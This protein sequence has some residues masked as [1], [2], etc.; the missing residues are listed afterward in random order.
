MELTR[1]RLVQGLTPIAGM[2]GGCLGLEAPGTDNGTPTPTSGG[3]DSGPVL[4]GYVVSDHV[5]TPTT[6][7]F[8]DMDPWG[9]FLA[10]GEVAEAYFA[11]GENGDVE[12]VRTFIDETAFGAGERLLYVHTY[13]PQTCYA[14]TLDRAPR[15]ATNGR[16]LV[17]TTVTRTAPADEPCGDAVTPVRILLRLSFDPTAGIPDA[18]DVRVAGHWDDSTELQLMAER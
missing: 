8:S 7:R 3:R 17:E 13:G 16:P 5:V 14:L 12:A 6:E 1:R 4:A 2:T 9:L 10:S 15:I 18:V 11:N